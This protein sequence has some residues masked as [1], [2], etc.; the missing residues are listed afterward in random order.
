MSRPE[1]AARQWLTIAVLTTSGALT[2][3]QFTLVIPV[4]AEFPGAL[5]VS[6]NDASWIVTITLLAGTVGTP[7][8][9]RMADM[10]GKRLMLLIALGLLF[11]GSIIAAAGMTY[12]T[13]LV[14]RA[15]QG[16]SSAIIP[17]GISLLRDQTS[18]RRTN[19]ASA[20]MSASLGVGSA[21]GLPLSGLLSVQ[22]GLASLFWFSAITSALFIAAIWMLVRESPLRSGGRFDLRGALL[23]TFVLVCAML[24]ISKGVPWGWTSPA[25]L[26]LVLAAGVGFAAWVP[27]QLRTP[28]AL[29]DLRT[30]RARPVLQTNVASFFATI[31]MFSN[32][33]LTTQQVMAPVS[34]GAG[35]GLGPV[36]A[37]LAM[38]PSAIALITLS[39]VSGMLLN[40]FGGRPV[41]AL[42]CT[43]MGLAFTI[44]LVNHSSLALIIIGATLVGVGTAIAFAAMP[45]LIMAAV[46]A[47]ESA[48]ANGI[49][50]L[51]R[52][53]GN[54]TASA[55]FGLAV[56][57]TPA[58]VAGVDYLSPGGLSLALTVA[59]ASAFIGA[60]LA[61]TLPRPRP[62][63]ELVLPESV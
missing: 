2:S 25:V 36:S 37:G 60:I 50:S 57:A 53:L 34:T 16:F 61:I 23:L 6:T 17:I 58:L 1:S 51:A 39:P 14:G 9:A 15:L 5:D 12:L 24:V 54:A 41:L 10:Y 46:P 44:R 7:I 63:D 18:A 11:A 49:N 59:G 29:V 4:L 56:S 55:G 42:G 33:L 26:G 21:L 35:L 48:A 52:S 27:L 3:L 19:S 32:H 13:V 38:L 31:A 20:W 8:L 45:S 30:S 43:I 28:S 40:R 62:L 22:F 47:S